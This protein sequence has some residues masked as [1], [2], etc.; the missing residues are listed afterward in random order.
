MP[1]KIAMTHLNRC[2]WICSGCK[3]QAVNR[4]PLPCVGESSRGAGWVSCRHSDLMGPQVLCDASLK[5]Y[6]WIGM[7]LKCGDVFAVSRHTLDYLSHCVK[8]R[9]PDEVDAVL[10]RTL[11]SA[12]IRSFREGGT[13]VTQADVHHAITAVT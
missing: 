2:G 1:D 8:G 7:M 12:V 9:S 11:E 3:R 10:A 5:S 6:V 13:T 4:P